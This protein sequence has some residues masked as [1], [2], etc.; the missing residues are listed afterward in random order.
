MISTHYYLCLRLLITI[1]CLPNRGTAFDRLRQR[2]AEGWVSW[3][4]ML[5]KAPLSEQRSVSKGA[6]SSFHIPPFHFGLCF[7]MPG[8]CPLLSMR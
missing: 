4:Q 5:K 2:G 6:F 7:Y 3:Q 8:R 1:F